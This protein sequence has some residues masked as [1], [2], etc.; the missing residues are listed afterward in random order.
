MAL[1]VFVGFIIVSL[2]GAIISINDLAI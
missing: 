2:M 1:S